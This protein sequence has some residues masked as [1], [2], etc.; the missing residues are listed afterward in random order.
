MLL[1]SM[2][3][4]AFFIILSVSFVNGEETKVDSAEYYEYYDESEEGSST[5]ELKFDYSMYTL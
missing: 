3:L 2:R 4:L 5:D 1:S